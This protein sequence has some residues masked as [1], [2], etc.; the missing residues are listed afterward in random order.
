MLIWIHAVPRHERHLLFCSQLQPQH[1]R[2]RLRRTRPA[3]NG[4]L[5]VVGAYVP[6]ADRMPPDFM[7]RPVAD[8]A[9]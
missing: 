3:I 8:V 5:A 1:A 7:G 9:L 6:A 4:A 2:R